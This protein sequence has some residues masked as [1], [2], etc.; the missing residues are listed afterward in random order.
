L[1]YFDKVKE[2]YHQMRNKKQAKTERKSYTFFECP[3][4]HQKQRAPR[5]KGRIR[6]T[7]KTCGIKFETNV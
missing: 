6:V 1:E 3:N 5:G 4:C 2:K 7:C